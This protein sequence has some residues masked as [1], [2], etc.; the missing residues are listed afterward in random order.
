MTVGEKRHDSLFLSDGE[1]NEAK[2][3]LR[4]NEDGIML[5]ENGIEGPYR[6][7]RFEGIDIEGVT[8]SFSGRL[9]DV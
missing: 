6:Y 5:S 8:K 1:L 9:S 3:V 7:L 4:I 2:N